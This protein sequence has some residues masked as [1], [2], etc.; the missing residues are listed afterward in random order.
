MQ[1]N[2]FIKLGWLTD[3]S[4]LQELYLKLSNAG[5]IRCEYSLFQLHFIGNQ[6]PEESIVWFGNQVE[7]ILLV[8]H[9]MVN[10]FIA[11]NRH[12]IQITCMHFRKPNGIR[13]DANTLRVLKS[14]PTSDLTDSFIQ[15]IIH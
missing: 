10:R 7:I 14:R 3:L 6:I 2:F 8:Q 11:Y 9:L 5:K 13:L 12:Y 15:N 1:K 4:K